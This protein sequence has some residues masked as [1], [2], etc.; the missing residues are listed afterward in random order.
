MRSNVRTLIT[1]SRLIYAANAAAEPSGEMK[2]PG[3]MPGVVC[4]RRVS[5]SAYQCQVD[6]KALLMRAAGGQFQEQ[7]EPVSSFSSGDSFSIT[8]LS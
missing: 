5:A 6:K 8:C 4:R 1:N 2:K 7:Q 3:E